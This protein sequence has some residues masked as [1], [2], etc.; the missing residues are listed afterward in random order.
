MCGRG[1]SAFLSALWVTR[2]EQL[3][4]C[5][6]VRGPASWWAGNGQNQMTRL[7]RGGILDLSHFYRQCERSLLQKLINTQPRTNKEMLTKL[8]KQ[9]KND[10]WKPSVMTRV[11]C[12]IPSSQHSRLSR[13]SQTDSTHNTGLAS[14]VRSHNHVKVR[15]RKHFRVIVRAVNKH[16]IS[17]WSTLK[18]QQA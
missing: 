7:K 14:S 16:N 6:R 1:Q 18:H 9:C 12:L 2:H 5:Q 13:E 4:V 11:T 10:H 15:T 8:I 17:T 3:Q